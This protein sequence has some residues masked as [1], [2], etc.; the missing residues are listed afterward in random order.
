MDS[1]LEAWWRVERCCQAMKPVHLAAFAAARVVPRDPRP[2]LFVPTVDQVLAAGCFDR[3]RVTLL[4]VVPRGPVAP[5]LQPDPT[6][7]MASHLLLA[8]PI[9]LAVVAAVEQGR[10]Y[11]TRRA[12]VV[13]LAS[14]TQAAERGQVYPMQRAAAEQREARPRQAAAVE[15]RQV[16]PT[17]LV[18]VAVVVRPSRRAAAVEGRWAYP[19]C[20]AAV[21][22]H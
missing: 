5:T 14:P 12:A 13:V 8:G 22:L 3:S 6:M 2:G 18:A 21:V 9:Q 17:R 1:R 10:V 16:N 4:A 11:P 7:E 20:R 19:C 15:R